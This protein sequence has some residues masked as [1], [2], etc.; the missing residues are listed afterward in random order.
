MSS[1]SREYK[2]HVLKPNDRVQLKTRRKIPFQRLI[3]LLLEGHEVF[4]ECDRRIAHYIRKRIEREID[5]LVEAYPSY[6]RNMEGYTFKLSL[7]SHILRR[8]EESPAKTFKREK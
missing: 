5:E 1:S 8:S 2:L 3:S 6:Y 7:V 4:I